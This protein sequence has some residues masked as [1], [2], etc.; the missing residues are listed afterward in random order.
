MRGFQFATFSPALVIMSFLLDLY[1]FQSTWAGILIK[2]IFILFFPQTCVQATAWPFHTWGQ[3]D[4]WLSISWLIQVG[5]VCDI[6]FLSGIVKPGVQTLHVLLFSVFWLF[7]CSLQ[8]WGLRVFGGASEVGRGS[9]I[10]HSDARSSR[11]LPRVGPWALGSLLIQWGPSSS[12]S[13]RQGVQVLWSD[14]M[15]WAARPEGEGYGRPSGKWALAPARRYSPESGAREWHLGEIGSVSF[16]DP[17]D[18]RHCLVTTAVPLPTHF[19]VGSR[20]RLL[21]AEGREEGL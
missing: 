16:Y 13:S 17:L 18:F 9:Q 4:Y 20:L 5:F 21:R 11:E 8:V 12:T 15:D 7:V 14:G 6:M 3:F 2:F 19:V 10:P 1:H